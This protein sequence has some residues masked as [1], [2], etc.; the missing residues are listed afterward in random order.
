MSYR[1]EITG[2]K[3]IDRW[4]GGAEGKPRD[5]DAWSNDCILERIPEIKD[6]DRLLDR[7]GL[8]FSKFSIIPDYEST[9]FPHKKRFIMTRLEDDGGEPDENG[10]WLAYYDIYVTVDKIEPVECP[11]FGFP[12]A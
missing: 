4:A 3:S 8:E 5:I 6:I 7:Y 2:I 11:D 10:A 12:K 1:I 9:N